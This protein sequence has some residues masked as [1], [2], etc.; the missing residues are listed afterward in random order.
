MMFTTVPAWL[1]VVAAYMMRKA[2][3]RQALPGSPRAASEVSRLVG[4]KVVDAYSK[5]KVSTI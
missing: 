3:G 1:V 2:P 4:P 5:M